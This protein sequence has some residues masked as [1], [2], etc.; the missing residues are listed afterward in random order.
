MPGAGARVEAK[1]ILLAIFNASLTLA[2]LL[3]IFVGFVY[4]QA[5]SFSSQVADAI[6]H[7]YK[8]AAKLGVLPFAIA[9]VLAG[10]S[11]QSLTAHPTS[12]DPRLLDLFW[13]ELMLVLLYGVFTILKYLA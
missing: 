3:L 11:F 8:N 9:I 6:T 12:L 2:G 4:S 7:R 5:Q 10:L 13:A 1:D